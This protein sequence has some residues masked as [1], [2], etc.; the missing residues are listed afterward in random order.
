MYEQ[1]GIVGEGNEGMY[2]CKIG[3]EG[4]IPLFGQLQSYIRISCQLEDKSRGGKEKRTH[5]FLGVENLAFLVSR[6]N[7]F[8]FYSEVT[9]NNRKKGKGPFSVFI[10]F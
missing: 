5:F 1:R 7:Q 4:S 2:V 8:P 9:N 10:I 3:R 6:H